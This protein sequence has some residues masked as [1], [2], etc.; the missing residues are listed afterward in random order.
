MD[1]KLYRVVVDGR[2]PV[3]LTART[4]H[5]ASVTFIFLESEAGRSVPDFKVE[6]IDDSLAPEQRIGLDE[7]LSHRSPGM[8][9]FDG[10]FGWSRP[11]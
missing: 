10:L 5:G 9:A 3:F 2:D 11:A 6:R 1:M 7:L 8:A 4:T